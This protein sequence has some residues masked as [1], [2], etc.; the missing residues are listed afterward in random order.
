MS[1]NTYV[2]QNT[3]ASCGG[4]CCKR[5]AGALF[6]SDIKRPMYRGL[7]ELLS[8]GMYQIDW[9]GK[10]PMMSFEELRGYTI[11]LQTGELKRIE[12]RARRAKAYY[13]RPAHVETRGI[14]FDHSEGKTGT[15]VFWDGEKGCT[16]TSKPAQ[17]RI[18]KPNHE[19]TTKCY[20]PNP[21]FGYLGS[22]RA[23]GLM[24]WPHRG[25]VRR[26]GRAVG[27]CKRL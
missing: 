1:V 24:W 25:V 6:P 5:H 2:D 20:Y 7:V 15:C 3:C 26:A 18:L 23:L 21:I 27:S 12:S 22:N 17:C 19:D 11:T 16:S 13:I 8:T 9:Y 10:N 14:L 4:R